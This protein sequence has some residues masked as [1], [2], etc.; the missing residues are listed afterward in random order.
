MPDDLQIVRGAVRRPA[1]AVEPHLVDLVGKAHVQFAFHAPGAGLGPVA[2]VVGPPVALHIHQPVGGTAEAEEGPVKDLHTWARDAAV[3]VL[4]KLEQGGRPAQEALG[5][6]GL[7]E[8]AL[9]GDSQAIG[10]LAEVRGQVGGQF[11]T[12]GQTQHD[13]QAPVR[14]RAHDRGLQALGQHLRAVTGA[15][16]IDRVGGR[17]SETTRQTTELLGLRP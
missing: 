5:G 15:D 2:P 10:L 8:D 6:A 7:D 9:R 4:E 14:S 11:E 1:E 13:L 12:L 16:D 3:F 17:E